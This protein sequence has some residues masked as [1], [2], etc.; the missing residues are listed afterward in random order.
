M[1]RGGITTI[2]IAVAAAA[3]VLLG[4][5]RAPIY[6]GVLEPPLDPTK[7]AFHVRVAF[8]FHDQQ[9][10]AMPDHD[11]DASK[12]V[13]KFPTKVTWTI[14][15]HGKKLGEVST[16]RPPGYGFSDIGLEGL[17]AGSS[18]PAIQEDAASFKTWLG[19]APDRPLVAVSAPNYQDPDQW[20]PFDVPAEMR[21]RVA[22]AF[23]QKIA[24]DLSCNGKP[25]RDYPASA[26]QI[27][28]KAYRS[29]N[30]DVLIAMNPHPKLNRCQGPPGDEWDSVWFHVQGDKFNW[31]GNG[32]TILD[33]GD[34]T[35]E[36]TSEIL[37]QYDGYNRDGYVLLDPR[38]DS[39][40]EF[41]WSYH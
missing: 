15:L 27:H 22:T 29:A 5:G 23:K 37:F 25:T 34:Y 1:K 32:L 11:D 9:W 13:A 40:N 6:L 41:A 30:G 19:A 38:D 33:F 36:G 20:K 10:S 21:E 28:G 24:L 8:L 17:A 16:V 7:G 26:L 4:A 35:G 14:A 12:A 18:A 3:A 39:R 31:I 2:S